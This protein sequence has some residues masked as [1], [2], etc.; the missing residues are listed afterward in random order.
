MIKVVAI[1]DTNTYHDSLVIPP[2]DILVHAGDFTFRGREKEV[3]DFGRWFSSIKGFQYK[4]LIAGNHDQSFEGDTNAQALEWLYNGPINDNF[5]YL[6]DTEIVLSINGRQ[7][8]VYGSPWQPFFYNWAFNL[9]RGNDLKDIWK[10]IPDDTEVLIT[11][12][13]PFDI[14]DECQDGSVVGCQDL[15]ERIS[16]LKQLKLHIFGHIHEAYGLK[17]YNGV[18]FVNACSC[19]AEYKIK[20]LPIIVEI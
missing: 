7:I 1:S 13:P 6:Q 3:R 2:G 4:I 9:Q 5:I 19:T 12:G 10:Q 8:K 14:L 18:K 15:A 20:N 16:K 17:E 11:H